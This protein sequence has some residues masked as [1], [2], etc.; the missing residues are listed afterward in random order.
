MKQ[1]IIDMFEKVKQFTKRIFIKGDNLLTE[2]TNKN[3]SNENTNNSTI[4]NVAKPKS[5]REQLEQERQMLV[6][7]K[8]YECG[9]VKEEELS[10]EQKSELI[11]VYKKQIK[12]LEERKKQCEL[13]ISNYKKQL[14]N[15]AFKANWNLF[16]HIKIMR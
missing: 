13:Q 15:V 14:E 6:L 8:K 9:E 3:S 10:Q 1:N 12:T 11:E 16:E 7:Q 2:G 5:M 4:Q